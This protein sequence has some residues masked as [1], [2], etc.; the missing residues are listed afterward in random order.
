MIMM[1]LFQRRRGYGL[2]GDSPKNC[3]MSHDPTKEGHEL[4]SRQQ[5]DGEQDS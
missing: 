5:C 1:F 2:A 4:V 3:V